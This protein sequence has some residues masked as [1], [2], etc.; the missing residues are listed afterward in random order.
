MRRA[1]ARD[2][3]ARIANPG[4]RVETHAARCDF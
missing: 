4:Y 3:R 1:G 2:G